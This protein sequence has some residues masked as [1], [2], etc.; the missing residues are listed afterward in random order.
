LQSAQ[1]DQLGHFSARDRAYTESIHRL[2][3][4][5]RQ[6]VRREPASAIDPPDPNVGV[7]D[8]HRSAPQSDSATGSVGRS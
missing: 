8:N 7:Q 1:F 5:Q 3:L 2:R 4:N 6:I